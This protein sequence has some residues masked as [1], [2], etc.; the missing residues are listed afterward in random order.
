MTVAADFHLPLRWTRVGVLTVLFGLSILSSALCIKM[1]ERHSSVK[2]MLRQNAPAGVTVNIKYTSVQTAVILLFLSANLVT[3]LSSHIVLF[4]LQDMYH[5]IPPSF[6]TRFNLQRALSRQPSNSTLVHQAWLFP[7]SLVL[8]VLP[9]GFLTRTVFMGSAT[10]VS[11]PEGSESAVREELRM[12]GINLAYRDT[13]YIRV[14]PLAS[15]P[16]VLFLLIAIAITF[17]AYLRR[18]RFCPDS[19]DEFAVPIDQAR[20]SQER[21][22]GEEVRTEKRASLPEVDIVV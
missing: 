20:S 2:H 4:L 9:L 17:A 12:L 13:P 1:F 5:V 8:F 14:V 15:Y 19:V 11:A 18:P 3:L 21:K 7:L 10:L 6:I 16:T 22:G